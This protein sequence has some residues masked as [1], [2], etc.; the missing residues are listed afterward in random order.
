MYVF[1][2]SPDSLLQTE[3]LWGT[4]SDK[5]ISPKPISV[6]YFVS[7]PNEMQFVFLIFIISLT[8]YS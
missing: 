6:L 7:D 4:G 2:I 5:G 1:I 3:Y 8:L